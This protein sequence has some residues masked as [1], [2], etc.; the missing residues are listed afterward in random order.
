[1]QKRTIYHGQVQIILGCNHGSVSTNQSMWYTS[2][3]KRRQKPHDHINRCR[4]ILQNST[5]IHNKNSPESE[6]R[7]NIPQNNKSHLGQTHN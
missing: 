3:T 2:L 5:P 4:K 7:G 6:H 1:M